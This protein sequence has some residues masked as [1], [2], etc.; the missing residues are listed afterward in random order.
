MPPNFLSSSSVSEALYTLARTHQITLE[1][2]EYALQ[3]IGIVPNSQ[4]W[5]NFLDKILLLLGTALLLAGVIFFFAYN[6]AD[7]SRFVKFGLLQTAILS[8]TIFAAWR[9]LDGLSGQAALLAAAVLVGALLAVYGQTY[10]TGADDFSLFLMWAILI[11]P[12]VLFGFFAPLWLLLLVLFNLSLILYW[13]QVINPIHDIPALFLLLFTLNGLALVAWEYAHK[14]GVA[15]L[16]NQ[17]F[18]QL[19]FCVALTIIV[20]P[21]WIA[22]L[23]VVDYRQQYSLFTVA[24]VLYIATTALSF[25]YYRYQRR[26]LLLLAASFFGILVILATFVSQLLP[27][28]NAISWLILALVVIGLASGATKLLLNIAQAWRQE[29]NNG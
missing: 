17:W 14:R 8:M 18:G 25:F 5:R 10:Q 22:I 4:A 16:Q 9:G 19:I 23:D 27:M 26:D 20:I 28:R 21:T 7:L 12:W 3:K 29:D 13:K 15:W 24:V 11:I 2:L 6:W 1:A